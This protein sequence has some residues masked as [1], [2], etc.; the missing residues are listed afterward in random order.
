M[1]QQ[2]ATAIQRREARRQWRVVK[3]ALTAASE[4]DENLSPDVALAAMWQLA[5]DAW[6]MTGHPLPAYSR[7]DTPVRRLAMDAPEHARPA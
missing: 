3:I 5:L 6:A 7:A 2:D 4:A 1:S